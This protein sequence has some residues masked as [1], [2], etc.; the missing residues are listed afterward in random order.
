MTIYTAVLWVTVDEHQQ[1]ARAAS[2]A[3]KVDTAGST[4]ADTIAH[5]A[6]TGDKQARHLLH[7]RRQQ[8]GLVLQGQCVT[9]Y[10]AHREWQ[11]AHISGIASARHHHFTKIKAIRWLSGL[12]AKAAA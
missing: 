8:G 10:H 7:H 1:L 5:H 2:D 3:A 6:A 12:T 4:A 11:V 9:V